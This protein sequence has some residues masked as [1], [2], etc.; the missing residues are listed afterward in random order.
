ML[1][2]KAQNLDSAVIAKNINKEDIYNACDRCNLSSVDLNRI[3][4]NIEEILTSQYDVYI[5]P[6]TD[7]LKGKAGYSICFRKTKISD[8]RLF[9]NR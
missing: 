2:Y 9:V 4:D 3:S 8:L 7:K 1:T 5:L 6:N